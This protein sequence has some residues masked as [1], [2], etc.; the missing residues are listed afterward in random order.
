L[1]INI[2]KEK[3]NMASIVGEPYRYATSAPAS[4]PGWVV[5]DKI[6]GYLDKAGLIY[7]KIRYPQPGDPAYDE[8]AARLRAQQAGMFGLPSPFGFLLLVGGVSLLAWG[9]YKIAK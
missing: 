9:I 7:N 4:G 1:L 3:N 2:L 8:A 6:F 5:T